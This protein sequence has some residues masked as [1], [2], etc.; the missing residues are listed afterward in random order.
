MERA[1]RYEY[2]DMLLWVLNAF[3]R[4]KSLLRSYQERYLYL[5]VDE[6]QDTNG[7]QNRLLQFLLERVESL[8]ILLLMPIFFALAG[9]NTT[10][11]AFAGAGL[12]AL[13][14]ILAIAIS[15]K[16]AGGALGARLAGFTW[17]ESFATGSLMNA[18]GLMEL[19]IINIGLQRGVISPALF[20]TLVIM[21]VITTLMASPIFELLVA[22]FRP[23][24]EPEP[25][26]S[27]AP[28]PPLA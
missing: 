17:R 15:G 13:L 22:R 8:A 21:A 4:H 7:A 16:I 5:L 14:L 24:P 27:P 23:E 6:Y 2:E 10:A 18:R 19:I 9:L 26:N 20:A 3:E 1:G 12:G 28:H 25:L 11:D